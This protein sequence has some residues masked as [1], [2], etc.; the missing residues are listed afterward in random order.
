MIKANEVIVELHGEP[1]KW[2][3]EFASICASLVDFG[4]PLEALEEAM[5]LGYETAKEEG[6][7]ARKVNVQE[8]RDFTEKIR[9]VADKDYNDFM[10]ALEKRVKSGKE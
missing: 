10:A 1:D 2:F 5:E 9:N 6:I 4:M 3:I 7:K 8:Y